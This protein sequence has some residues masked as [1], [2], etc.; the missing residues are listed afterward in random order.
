[1]GDDVAK[2]LKH[3]GGERVEVQSPVLPATFCP[4]LLSL[5]MVFSVS[6]TGSEAE[7]KERKRLY[8]KDLCAVQVSRQPEIIS[9][10]IFD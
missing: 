2:V 4:H 1:M 3:L 5:R 9:L 8:A 7:K 10:A 6:G